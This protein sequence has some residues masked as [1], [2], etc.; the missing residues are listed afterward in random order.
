[1]RD[2]DYETMLVARLR[3]GD[4][5]AMAELARTYGARLHQQA[6]RYMK[7]VEDA[8]EVVQDVL[9]KVHHK[10]DAF[11]GEAALSSWL[12]R[13]TFNTAMS[14]LRHTRLARRFEREEPVADWSGDD[15][16]RPA[17]RRQP[18]DWSQMADERILRRQMRRRL[19][20]AM[21]RLPGIYRT[22]IVLRDLHG[23]STD[24]ASQALGVKDQT[25]KS[26]LH[27]GRLIL[28]RHLTDFA[29]GLSMHRPVAAC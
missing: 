4:E 29:G 12:H 21:D 19:R 18:A 26:R 28:R 9:M 16:P 22:P 5:D 11:R 3:R 6:L 24:E 20:A 25:M 13:V 15:G 7:N 8:E 14:H 10:I 23:L 27:R 17:G 2:H 1:M